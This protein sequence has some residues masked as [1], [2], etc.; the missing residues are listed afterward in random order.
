[1]KMNQQ[2]GASLIS[3]LVG[4]LISGIVIIGMLV[5]Y[6]NTIHAVVPASEDARSD[7]ERVS[8]ILA[9]QMM[10]QDAGFGIDPA[11]AYGT[12]LRV[13]I[14]ASL[15]NGALSGGS[16]ASSGQEGNAVLW[17]K[18]IDGDDL[19]EG[20]F[21]DDDGGLWRITTAAGCTA[22]NSGISGTASP[23]IHQSRHPDGLVDAITFIYTGLS[24]GASCR[25][26]GIGTGVGGKATVM[27][28]VENSTG[29]S[30]ES[31]ACLANF[32]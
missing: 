17:R 16:L 14:G 7:G 6:R 29:H 25:P 32:L 3:V 30:I 10:L 24:S 1:M 9:A 26:F 18:Q 2:Q 22:I 13:M 12:D 31:T 23:L 28:K 27:I 4:L 5:V 11:P 8:G 19:C 15:S 21:A 20:L